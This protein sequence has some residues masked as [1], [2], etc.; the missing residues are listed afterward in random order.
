MSRCWPS[1]DCDLG[2]P[3]SWPDRFG[4]HLLKVA[5]VVHEETIPLERCCDLTEQH[6][7]EGNGKPG[8]AMDTIRATLWQPTGKS[9]DA[10][11]TEALAL[12][13]S[14]VDETDYNDYSMNQ[15]P[16]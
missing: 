12:T 13:R 6:M 9:A 2:A 14:A 1:T 3:S 4:A 5:C 8:R 15:L 10:L 11:P 7:N 16:F